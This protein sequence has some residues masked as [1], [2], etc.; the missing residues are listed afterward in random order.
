MT[1]TA[2]I[3]LPGYLL[4]GLLAAA[5]VVSGDETIVGRRVTLAAAAG[6]V[7]LGAL[8]L[9]AVGRFARIG[10]L[11]GAN[12]PLITIATLAFSLAGL[13]VIIAMAWDNPHARRGVFLGAVLLFLF[14]QWG[15]ADQ[16][17]RLGANDPRE[18]WVVAGTDDDAPLMV[19]LLRRASR[20]TANSDRDLAVFS[21]VD[22]PALRWYLRD[23]TNFQVGPALPFN[24]QPD[25]VIAPLDAQLGLPNDYFGADFGLERREVGVNMPSSPE[26][27]LRWWLFRESAAPVDEERVVVWVRSD[28][29]GQE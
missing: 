21:L 6:L 15:A 10:L 13:A 12:G 2:V 1:N 27:A 18:R 23:F 11:S 28:L 9:T 17:S 26:A 7:G 5:V 8:L 25:V 4:V 14:W 3:L 16:L 29:A 19:D 22:S 20:Q 24:A